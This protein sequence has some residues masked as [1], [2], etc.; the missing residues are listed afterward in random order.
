MTKLLLGSV[1]AM[2]AC[3]ALA[4]QHGDP[5]KTDTPINPFVEDSYRSAMMDNRKIDLS[6]E[7]PRIK[8][9]REKI[10]AELA[11]LKQDELKDTDW[12]KEWAGKYYTGDGLGEN[13]SIYLAPQN[14]ISFLNYGCLG[15]Y[16]A[17]HG[18]VAGS[19]PGELKLALKFG[20]AQK[21]FL[22]ERVFLVKWG[23]E[24]FFVPDWQMKQFV[25]NYNKGGYAKSSMFG[26]ARLVKDGKSSRFFQP[27]SGRPQL[28]EPY[29][30]M[31]RD[32]PL[33]LKVRKVIP[34]TSEPVTD[35]VSAQTFQVEFEG[36]V[37]VGV[38]VGMEFRY[39][40]NEIVDSGEFRIIRADAAICVAE[41]ASYGRKTITPPA[42]G[43][44]LLTSEADAEF[45]GAGTPS[46]D[47]NGGSTDKK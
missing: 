35:S 13:V 29:A 40:R 14:G 21:S 4:F 2:T 22:S 46:T 6:S 5:E 3:G 32:K 42:V 47:A 36:G 26:I 9:R 11:A 41:F 8:E 16:G 10:I 1:L 27:A 31:L 24:R 15:L 45:P 43:D 38:Y 23:D 30:K 12:A 33:S 18:E 44:V 7:E 34:G 28:P 37:D 17:D 39:P 25:N 20:T 19:S